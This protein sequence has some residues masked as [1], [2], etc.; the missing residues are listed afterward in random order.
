VLKRRCRRLATP[1]LRL[2]HRFG[3]RRKRGAAVRVDRLRVVIPH[4]GGHLSLSSLGISC[5][6]EYSRC[7][8]NFVRPAVTA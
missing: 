5:G 8:R 3:R 2:H 1:R 4:P 7:P 6:A